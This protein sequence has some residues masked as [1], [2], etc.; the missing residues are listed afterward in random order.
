L[1]KYLQ[2]TLVRYGMG[3]VTRPLVLIIAIF[4]LFSVYVGVKHSSRETHHEGGT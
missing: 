1:E 2:I 3:F 4:I